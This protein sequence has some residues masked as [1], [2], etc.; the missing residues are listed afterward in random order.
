VNGVAIQL[1]LAEDTPLI[2]ACQKAVEVARVLGVDVQFNYKGVD[3]VATQ[4]DDPSTIYSMY[5][6]YRARQVAMGELDA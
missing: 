3:L 1:A 5:E 6:R 4:H 2:H